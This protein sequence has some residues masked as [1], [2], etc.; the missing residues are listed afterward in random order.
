MYTNKSISLLSVALFLI[1]SSLVHAGSIHKWVDENGV[2]HYS[3][4]APDENFKHVDQLDVTDVYQSSNAEDDYY[5][6]SKQWERAHAQRVARKQLQIEKAKLKQA[7][8][9]VTP[10]VVYVQ[11]ENDTRRKVY[12]PIYSNGFLNRSYPGHNGYR[13]QFNNRFNS[14]NAGTGYRLPRNR[15]SHPGLTLTIR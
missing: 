15:Y 3:D 2:T 13:N 5:S 6:A 9:Q 11:Q 4:Q 8:A 14:R 1:S 7:K 12:Y 10:Q